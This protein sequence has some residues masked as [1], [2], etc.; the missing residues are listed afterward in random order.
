MDDAKR[1]VPIY[2]RGWFKGTAAVI[3]GGAANQAMYQ[4]VYLTA[5]C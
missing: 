4:T 1:S 2:E 5:K 3:G